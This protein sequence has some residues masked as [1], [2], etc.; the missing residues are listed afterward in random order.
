MKLIVIAL[1][2]ISSC[3][4]GRTGDATR[5]HK[6]EAGAASGRYEHCRRDTRMQRELSCQSAKQFAPGH[7]RAVPIAKPRRRRAEIEVRENVICRILVPLGAQAYRS[8]CDV[9]SHPRG[10][11]QIAVL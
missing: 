6:H 4:C 7:G 10:F 5:S 9:M 8:R 3:D 11:S 2:H 1:W